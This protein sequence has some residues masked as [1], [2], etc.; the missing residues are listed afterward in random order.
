MHRAP[1]LSSRRAF[2]YVILF[3]VLAV[4]GLFLGRPLLGSAPATALSSELYSAT[5]TA[6]PS[7][8]DEAPATAEKATDVSSVPGLDVKKR[9]AK[10]AKSA[11]ATSALR[12]KSVKAKK[13]TTATPSPTGG[14]SGSGSGSGSS[15]DGDGGNATPVASDTG[16]AAEM[17]T[18][19]NAERAK[20]KCKPLKLNT[21]LNNAAQAHTTDMATNNY[22]SH[23]SQDGRTPFD[24]IEDAGYAYSAAAENIAAGGTTAAGAMN[25]WMNSAGHKANILNCMYVELGVGYAKGVNADYAGY[26]TQ[27][28][29]TPL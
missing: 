13:T 7:A 23:N 21:D 27:D 29:G 10:I 25:Q 12:I 24:R 3:A 14:T 16:F 18:L 17:L 19:V 15:D 22:F 11:A 5:P 26:W 9:V 6:V 20:V 8:A 1:G 2:L 4:V 28:F